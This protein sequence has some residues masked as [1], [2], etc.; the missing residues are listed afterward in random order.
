[1]KLLDLRERDFVA[2]LNGLQIAYRCL[3][4]EF[5]GLQRRLLRLEV[6][7]LSLRGGERP[8][9]GVQRRIDGCLWTLNSSGRGGVEPRIE[10]LELLRESLKGVGKPFLLV[11]QISEVRVQVL[12]R[13][14]RLPRHRRSCS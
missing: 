5:K 8:V 2:D 14:T 6:L 10:L 11:D 3:I 13:L 12:V 7:R 9:E 1:M 4:L